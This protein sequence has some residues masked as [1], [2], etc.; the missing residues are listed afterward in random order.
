MR[1]DCGSA[2]RGKVLLGMAA[3]LLAA[4]LAE[5]QRNGGGNQ[6]QA[7]QTPPGF[8]VIDRN[9]SLV[10]YAVTENLVAREINGVW[11]TFYFHPGHGIYDSGAV[12]LHYL[13]TDCSG[14]A[15]LTHYSTFSDG[16]RVGP[17]LYFPADSQTL[18]PLSVRL[19]HGNGELGAC[20]AANNIEG[21]YGAASTA[22]IDSFKLVLPFR[23]VR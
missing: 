15:Y 13:T 12:Y 22:D 7:A 6:Q 11:V 10:G 2:S 1:A 4:S 23:A 8:R 19:G 17:K 16:T 20:T 14:P 9:G 3:L 21:V 18:N 5:A